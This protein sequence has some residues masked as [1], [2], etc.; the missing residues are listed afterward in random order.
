M[1][2]CHI[3]ASAKMVSQ[4]GFVL[5]TK[6]YVKPF[7]FSFVSSLVFLSIHL[8]IT[9]SC[10]PDLKADSLYCETFRGQLTLDVVLLGKCLIHGENRCVCAVLVL[11]GSHEDDN[12]HKGLIQNILLSLT[13]KETAGSCY[14]DIL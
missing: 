5:M 10:K 2:K 11:Y 13:P 7:I 1:R 4:P 14:G 9:W 8:W 6:I 12:G 3:P